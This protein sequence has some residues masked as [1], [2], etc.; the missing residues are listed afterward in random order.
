LPKAAQESLL[1]AVGVVAKAL[2]PPEANPEELNVLKASLLKAAKA[3]SLLKRF[4]ASAG[5]TT[6]LKGSGL[7]V[8][9]WPF[10]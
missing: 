5:E 7:V 2:E 8:D 10:N 9:M 4:C 1:N 3:S 6:L